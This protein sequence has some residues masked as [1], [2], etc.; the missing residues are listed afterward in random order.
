M[1]GMIHRAIRDMV[2]TRAGAAA[3]QDIEAET[4]AG[5]AEMIG[6]LVYDDAITMKL[7]SAAAERLNLSIPELLEQFGRHWIEYTEQ[8]QFGRILDLAGSDLVSV[9]KN[10]DRLHAA[11]LAAMPSARAPSFT[12]T[13]VQ[14]NSVIL[15]YRSQRKGLEPL[16]KGLLLGLLNRFQLHGEVQQI[17]GTDDAVQ[18]RISH[19][20][21]EFVQ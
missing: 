15:K 1:Y 18:F 3:W 17:R 2:K 13:E 19:R 9:L 21:R 16:I 12:V 7:L 8:K 10:L 4:G 5:P 14:D 20:Q 6:V 11:V